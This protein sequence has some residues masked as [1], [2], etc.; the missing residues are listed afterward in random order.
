MTVRCLC[1]IIHFDPPSDNLQS[2]DT[3]PKNL[4]LKCNAV[5]D[6]RVSCFSPDRSPYADAEQF[7]RLAPLSSILATSL[8]KFGSEGKTLLTPRHSLNAFSEP[9][10]F[11][12]LELMEAS[13]H[14]LPILFEV[15]YEMLNFDV[16]HWE[17]Q[18]RRSW[19]QQA[20]TVPA[21]LFSVI[22]QSSTDRAPQCQLWALAFVRK[23]PRK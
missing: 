13:K 9:R 19:S 18:S 5:W 16:Y 10:S 14:W 7:S 22:R 12:T 23:E 8:S 6:S 11:K 21:A 1:V 20:V 15:E 17:R 4:K 2:A 3:F